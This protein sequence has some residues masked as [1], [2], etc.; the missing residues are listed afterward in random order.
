MSTSEPDFLDGVMRWP[1]R[2][3][4][5]LRAVV[6]FGSMVSVWALRGWA[7]IVGEALCFVAWFT[8]GFWSIL[9]YNWRRAQ[10]QGPS[11]G[12]GG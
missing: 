1:T 4:R 5:L 11:A 6:T 9:A 3:F 8:V 2:R 10:R 7:A 12:K